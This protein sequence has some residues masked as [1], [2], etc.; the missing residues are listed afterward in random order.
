MTIDPAFD[1]E[2]DNDWT[3]PVNML[4]IKEAVFKHRATVIL[5]GATYNITYLQDKERVF[6]KIKDNYA[7]CGYFT[8]ERLRRYSA[9]G[10]YS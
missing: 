2:K 6:L 8:K 7:P 9:E 4:K 1:I 5:N 10:E 3:S